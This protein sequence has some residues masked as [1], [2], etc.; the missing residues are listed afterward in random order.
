[1]DSVTKESIVFFFFSSRRRHTRSD[2]DWSS[3]VCSSDLAQVAADNRGRATVASDGA[4]DRA[5]FLHREISGRF[6]GPPV[7]RGI[8]ELP[9]SSDVAFRRLFRFFWLANFKSPAVNE[10]HFDFRFFLEEVAIG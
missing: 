5:V 4:G 9:F 7:G 6:L 8:G 10:D 1:M 3:D 2:R